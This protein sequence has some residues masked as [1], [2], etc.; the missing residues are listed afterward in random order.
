MEIVLDIDILS[1]PDD[2][3][4]GP[5]CLHAVYK[6]YNDHISL[7]EIIKEVK[8]LEEGGTLAVML[9]NHALERGYR[10]TI[11]TYNLEVFDPTWFREGGG[12]M[13]ER[14]KMQREMKNN[15][16]LS[17]AT[18]AYIE[19]LEKGGRLKLKDLDHQLIRHYLKQ[20]RPI[21]TGLSAT[22]LYQS[23]REEL[24]EAKEN[25]VGGY[26]VGHFVVLC[27]YDK[28]K[29]TVTVAD[30]YK[31]YEKRIYEV[32]LDRLICSILLGIVTHDANL[33][34]IEPGKRKKKAA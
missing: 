8:S 31:Y 23:M 16:K 33:L 24:L 27:G 5:T 10:A 26:P 17:L 6:Y 11:Y 2:T 30:P 15:S 34:V 3:T 7:N 32:G 21:L 18:N 25:D 9:A 28:V 4:C 13:V 19:F 22:Y 12:D 29:R 1:Q 14:L 20:E